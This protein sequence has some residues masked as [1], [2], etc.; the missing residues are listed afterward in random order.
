MLEKW[1]LRRKGPENQRQN[2]VRSENV[3][4]Q[5]SGGPEALDPHWQRQVHILGSTPL[6]AANVATL[7][8]TLAAMQQTLAGL[9][10]PSTTAQRAPEVSPARAEAAGLSMPTSLPEDMRQW[11]E[12]LGVSYI[13]ENADGNFI[14]EHK[15]KNGRI[16]VDS[17]T[18]RKFDEAPNHRSGGR[19]FGGP[20]R[21]ERLRLPGESKED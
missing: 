3:G 10:A 7:Q 5:N 16:H 1:G 19:I 8:Q 9:Q 17:K 15:G 2:P 18:F 12:Q 6:N 13:G 14:F 20:E 4:Q 11:F 21:D